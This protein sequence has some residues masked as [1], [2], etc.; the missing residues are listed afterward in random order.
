MKKGNLILTYTDPFI[1]GGY[2]THFSWCE[3]T[4]FLVC[5]II[6]QHTLQTFPTFPSKHNEE[7]SF[8]PDGQL[9]IAQ[10]GKVHH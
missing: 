1:L 8:C 5:G 9:F 2:L 4:V 6:I 10:E 3:L 7:G